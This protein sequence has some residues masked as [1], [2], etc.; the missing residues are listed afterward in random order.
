MLDV[1]R[2]RD[3]DAASAALLVVSVLLLAFVMTSPAMSPL[4][5]IS[6]I[7][8]DGVSDTSDKFPVDPLEW[9]DSD[10][11]G[12][13]DKS[14]AFPDDPLEAMDSDNDGIGDV[15]DF[16][17]EGNGG[18]RVS[19]IKFEFEGYSS[20]YNRIKY[21]PDAWFEIRLDTDCDGEFDVF[22][23]SEVFSC[24]ERLESFFVADFDLAD[25]SKSIRF[26]ILVYDV[27]DMDNNNVTDFEIIDYIPVD[28]V[29]ADDA[30]VDLPCC[31]TWT[32]CG[33][34]DN[35]TPDCRMEYSAVTVPLD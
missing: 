27:W 3:T 4:A 2:R 19:L 6:D 34:G 22:A 1:L 5:S 20:E 18:I 26:S 30:T 24:V 11:D 28:G 29:L 25:D 33:E 9:S 10:G 31:C 35:E 17:D 12:V 8:G 23:Q 13:G 7:D 15:S 21:C 32:Y 16:L 14:D